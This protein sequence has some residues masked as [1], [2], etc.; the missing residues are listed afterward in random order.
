MFLKPTESISLGKLMINAVLTSLNSNS[1]NDRSSV[2]VSNSNHQLSKDSYL[3][4]ISIIKGVL[5]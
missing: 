4:I 5:T 2:L 3:H 1:I